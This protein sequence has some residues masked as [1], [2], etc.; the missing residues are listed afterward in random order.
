MVNCL[1]GLMNMDDGKMKEE[2]FAIDTTKLWIHGNINVDFEHENF[3]LTLFP[4]SKTAR[5]FSLQTPI[6]VNG[7]FSKTSMSVTPFDLAG[8]Y[9]KFITSPLHVPTRWVFDDKPPKDGSAVCEKLFD[10]KHVEKLNAEIERQ[11]KQDM[12]EML[13]SD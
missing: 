12:K 6:R 4:R 2:L 5:L 7:S 9:V 13:E 8:T 10:R 1:V 11:E 3:D